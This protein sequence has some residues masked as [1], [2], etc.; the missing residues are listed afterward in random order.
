[1]VA[2]VHFVI[3]TCTHMVDRHSSMMNI[4]SRLAVRVQHIPADVDWSDTTPQ[5]AV[6]SLTIDDFLVSAEEA[7]QFTERA[8]EYTA[9]FL[10]G[11]F[12][13]IKHLE[14]FLTQIFTPV[15]TEYVP[16]KVLFK[17]EKFISETIEILCQLVK[18]ASLNGSNQV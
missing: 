12:K 15:K 9:R 11:E 1:M 17:D 14:K 16:M 4:T 7:A 3:H 18:D 6:E 8:V 2:I 13:A 5:R 10:T